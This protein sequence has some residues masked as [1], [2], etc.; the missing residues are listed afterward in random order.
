[1]TGFLRVSGYLTEEQT[2]RDVDV[3]IVERG[4]A[5]PER[6]RAAMGAYV[7]KREEQAA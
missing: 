4:L 3:V 1:V 7:A 6:F 2:W 5:Q